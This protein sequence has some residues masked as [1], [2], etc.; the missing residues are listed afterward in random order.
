MRKNLLL[1]RAFPKVLAANTQ[2][3][4]INQVRE[5]GDF[6]MM[7]MVSVGGI[8]VNNADIL[9]EGNMTDEAY[10]VFFGFANDL[11]GQSYTI[12]MFLHHKKDNHTHS[13]VP[14]VNRVIQP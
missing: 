5:R 13:P 12:G 4:L 10:S 11:I 9:K 14:I 1:S 8:I 2:Y 6:L 7:D 3:A